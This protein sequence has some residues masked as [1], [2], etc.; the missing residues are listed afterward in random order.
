MTEPTTCVAIS[1][2]LEV[3]FARANELSDTVLHFERF[4]RWK[5]PDCAEVTP[6]FTVVL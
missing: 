6:D 1:S 5:P 2:P 3:L 4:P